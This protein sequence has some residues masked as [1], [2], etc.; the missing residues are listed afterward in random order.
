MTTAYCRQP[1][2]LEIV[3]L[4]EI[5]YLPK[6]E[7][8]M[9]VSN[10]DN[11]DIFDIIY[12]D[13]LI[14][15][16]L[17]E[18]RSGSVTPKD[19]F[20][21]SV[22]HFGRV[23][24]GY[25]SEACG[26]SEDALIEELEGS[27]IWKDP[28][29]Y[30]PASPYDG[31]LI[32]EQYVRGNIYRLLDEAESA[33]RRTGLFSP[34]I[35]LLKSVLPDC[36]DPE[37]IMISLGATWVPEE[38]YLQF[39][40][41]LLEMN[42]YP[43]QLYLDSFLGKWVLK[44]GSV[45][46]RTRSE[47]VYGTCRMPALRIIE[48]TMN[49]SPI[50]IYDRFRDPGSGKTK[51]VLNKSDTM[52][53]HEKQEVILREFQEWLSRNPGIR[54]RLQEIYTDKYG[55]QLFHYDGSFL[56][57]PD[58]NPGIRLYSHQRAA[59]A[60]IILSENNVLLSHA[61]GAGKTFAFT[62]GIHERLRMG[63]SRKALL[64]V[65]NAVFE[66]TVNAI[67]SLYPNETFVPISVKDFI[68]SKREAALRQITDADGGFF[69][70]ASSS[71]DMIGMS[72][73]YR[74]D[75]K[76][77]EISACSREIHASA[78]R[79]RKN[80]LR[81]LHVRLLAEYRKL[82]ER[83]ERFTDCFDRMGIDLLVV[84]ECH[85]YKNI[86]L[87]CSMDPVV[88]LHS[89]GTG[90]ADLMLE[91]CDYVRS[92]GGKLV[93]ATGTPLTNS[94]ADLFVLQRYLQPEE[95]EFLNISRF[96]E[97]A[98]TFCTKHTEF[99]IDTTAASFRFVTRFDRFHNL[100][101]L[102]ALFGNVCDFYTIDP[103][104]LKLPDFNGHINIPVPRSEAQARYI[105]KI[106]ERTEAIRH[107]RVNPAKDNYLKITTDGRKCALDVR[108][109]V[110][111]SVH[112][113]APIISKASS[114]VSVIRRIYDEYP[115]MTQAVFC[116][117]STP[118]KDFNLY[119]EIRRLLADAGI[120]EE[121]VAFIHSASTDAARGKLIRKFNAGEIR[122]LLGSTQKLGLGVNI[123]E[124]LVAIHHIDAPWKP[125][126][127]VQ[128]EGRAIRQGNLN[129]EVL[130]YRYVTEG[131]FDAYTWQILE[132]K[133][134]F[135]S[136]FLSG[137]LDRSHRSE[138]DIGGMILNYSE[139][140]ALA[141][142]NP[143]IK[144]RVELSN[145]LS[146]ARAGSMQRLEELHTYRKLLTELPAQ[147]DSLREK[148]AAMTEDIK[149]YGSHRK[150]SNKKA[151]ERFGN[152]LLRSLSRNLHTDEEV[153]ACWYRGFRII[154]PPHQDPLRPYI[155]LRHRRDTGY[156]VDMKDAKAGGCSV[157]IDNVLQTLPDR[158][159]TLQSRLNGLL[160][161]YADAEE[162]LR[163]GNPYV[164]KIKALQDELNRLDAQLKEE[165]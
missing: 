70:L 154:I 145:T 10:T 35:E 47:H 135:I 94:M 106:V 42:D 137:S 129:R 141:I 51:S 40:C 44:G 48:H 15:T 81:T 138:E 117:I 121:E 88:G 140:K 18:G 105:R 79:D 165:I 161:S 92:G 66:S 164:Q 71:F 31:W 4:Y 1:P 142:G 144:K 19:A 78:D 147:C 150:S 157:R 133:Q 160:G 59:A 60:R 109:V 67:R 63:L 152:E 96:N 68:P 12:D 127:L 108:L 74:L 119:D 130:I 55:Y 124:R 156:R 58:M 50:R 26:R 77:A 120:P 87:S 8:H 101:E 151:R 98:N 41:E 53:A 28:R 11:A 86:S 116:D 104:E 2:E 143:L 163:L 107:G 24:L 57:L 159:K 99:E 62:S 30:D 83:E 29:S 102:M 148:I 3:R 37:D 162:Q 36:P 46:N 21:L 89:K 128:R 158:R 97:W 84:D 38:Y 25:M 153:P 85:N 22:N 23:N 115:G 110:P 17:P 155:L 73:Q 9:T 16:E 134:R 118:G 49:A 90:K 45:Y 112:A 33:D 95:L 111:E 56:D 146:R 122:V 139:I 69:V 34:N 80:R 6:K 65:P 27:L 132:N 136:S 20:V 75:K 125:S 114:A 82:A 61:V 100:P 54:T 103:K 93:F 64:V 123:Q 13:E 39:I 131:S 113:E 76:K 149:L 32:R 72:K 126:D 5:H 52:A 14:D 7:V 91:K 43:P